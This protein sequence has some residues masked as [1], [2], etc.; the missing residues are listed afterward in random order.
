MLGRIA[1]LP[2]PMGWIAV[3]SEAESAYSAGI[4]STRTKWRSYGC[5]LQC[6][7]KVL[8]T[9]GNIRDYVSR[10]ELVVDPVRTCRSAKKKFGVG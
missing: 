9:E 5:M 10:I 4:S 1:V 8:D 6:T 3:Q 7:V 2:V